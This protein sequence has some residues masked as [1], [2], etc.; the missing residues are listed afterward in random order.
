MHHCPLAFPRAGD[1]V[2]LNLMGLRRDDMPRVGDIL[3]QPSCEI[4]Q[5]HCFTATIQVL[6]I[7]NRLRS[8]W[9]PICFVHTA[10]A[11]VRLTKIVW[12]LGRD[13]GGERLQDPPDLRSGDMASA[14]FSVLWP[15][16]TLNLET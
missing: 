15:G 5:V 16:S 11:Q 1:I 9:A 4:E 7:P 3:V 10:H 2:G 14:E 13:T 8:N 6:D 12:R